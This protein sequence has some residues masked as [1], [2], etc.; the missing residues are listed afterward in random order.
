MKIESDY[1]WLCTFFLM[2]G[3]IA[4]RL[5]I[6]MISGKV[7]ISER[8][9]QLFSFIPAAILPA[10]VAPAAFFHN[11]QVVTFMGKERLLVL[12]LATV[13]SYYTRST[14][15]TI[16]FGLAALFVATNLLQLFPA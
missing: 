5:S 14:L 13:V 3:T 6:I 12:I 1:F 11:G 10:F 4:I 2:I 8:V 15:L 16:V 7:K 9:K